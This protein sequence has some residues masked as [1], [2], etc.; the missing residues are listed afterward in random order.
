MLF[1]CKIRRWIHVPNAR[2]GWLLP[3]APQGCLL[4]EDPAT[5]GLGALRDTLEYDALF[6]PYHGFCIY[7]VAL[8][9]SSL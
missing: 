8:L 6:R 1:H 7:N 9:A 3:L 4:K 5:N 2:A